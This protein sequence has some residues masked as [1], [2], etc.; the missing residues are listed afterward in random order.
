MVTTIAK[1]Y[2]NEIL[3]GE[4]Q[5]Q[6]IEKTEQKVEQEKFRKDESKNIDILA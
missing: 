1:N 3:K 2:I 4:R 6:K 5:L